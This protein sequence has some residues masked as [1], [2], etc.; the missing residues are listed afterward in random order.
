MEPGPDA[1]LCLV[2]VIIPACMPLVTPQGLELAYIGADALVILG[3]R[4]GAEP[5]GTH[6]GWNPIP[7]GIAVTKIT[8]YIQS[9]LME[10]IQVNY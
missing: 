8:V 1:C 2:L 5:P 6:Q 4:L 3:V 7:K 10:C 9:V